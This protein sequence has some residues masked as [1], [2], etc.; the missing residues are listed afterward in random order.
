MLITSIH[1]LRPLL[2]QKREWVGVLWGLQGWGS[3]TAWAYL[4]KPT[5]KLLP[6]GAWRGHTLLCAVYLIKEDTCVFGKEEI[7]MKL[8]LLRALWRAHNRLRR[9][10][11]C[12]APSPCWLFCQ[13]APVEPSAFSYCLKSPSRPKQTIFGTTCSDV[14]VECDTTHLFFSNASL[15]TWLMTSQTTHGRLLFNA[16]VR[17]K[18]Q[19]VGI[20]SLWDMG[21]FMECVLAG[22][23][24]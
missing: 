1:G 12:R 22:V 24:Q 19:T 8:V 7:P 21:I 20:S 13:T 9:D 18:V 23:W 10:A 2:R 15:R 11:G 17:L 4:L 14:C 5:F 6:W 3:L 16:C